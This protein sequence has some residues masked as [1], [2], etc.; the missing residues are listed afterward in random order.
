[1]GKLQL[2]Q[3]ACLHGAF[4]CGLIVA[5][6][7]LWLFIS[8]VTHKKATL[9]NVTQK[10]EATADQKPQFRHNEMRHANRLNDCS[11]S[12]NRSRILKV[13]E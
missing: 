13:E 5:F 10:I 1:M 2:D 8:W 12:L 9:Q 11:R 4:D 3:L 7:Q 6:G